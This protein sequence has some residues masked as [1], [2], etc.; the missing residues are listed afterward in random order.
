MKKIL[1]Y[2]ISVIL[3]FSMIITS[4][5]EGVNSDFLPAGQSFHNVLGLSDIEEIESA[6]IVGNDGKCADIEEKDLKDWLNI[7]W[8]F[9]PFDRVVAPYEGYVYP[10]YYIRLWTKDKGKAYVVHPNSGVIVGAY[11]E[12]CVSHGETK[13]NY[14]WYLPYIGNGRN[15]LYLADTKLFQKY[16]NEKS[17]N[18]VDSLRN[19]T[20]Y[21]EKIL[22]DNNLLM[23]DGASA[24]AESE[25]QKAASCN[26]LP[27]ELTGKY[28]NSITRMEFCNLIYRL[29]ATEFSPYS[30]S[31]MG[32]WSAIDNIVYERKLTDKINFV[33]FSDCED[34]KIKFLAGAGIIC[35]MGD[36]TFAPDEFLTREQA[37]TIL[38]RTAEFLGNKTIIKSSYSKIYADENEIS[39][40]A[41]PSVASMK[42]ME[43]M[44]GVSENV[45][46]PKGTYTVEQAVATMVRL[47]ECY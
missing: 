31:R 8:N 44:K 35:G 30:D 13:K 15:A 42:A 23:I 3:L 40:W 36:G 25:I 6:V 46:A 26:L 5:A 47:Y 20:S 7:Y 21:D 39:D 17:E 34:D 12:P 14:V 45:F 38:C 11:G 32:Q 37:A 29:I 33:S 1:T 41:I 28:Q 16:L 10:E 9:E 43:I 27:Y 24:W 4:V 19:T 22:P 2:I 18:F